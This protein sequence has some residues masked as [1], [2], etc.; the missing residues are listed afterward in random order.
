[1][2]TGIFQEFLGWFGFDVK[3][4]RAKFYTDGDKRLI[5]TSMP[6]IGKYTVEALKIPKARNGCIKVAGATLSFNEYLQKFEEVSGEY[7]LHCPF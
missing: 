4:K 6:D 7:Q 3:N 5:T 2:F 1:M